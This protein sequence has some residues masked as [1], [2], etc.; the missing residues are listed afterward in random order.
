M[1]V[2][3]ANQDERLMSG[4]ALQARIEEHYLIFLDNAD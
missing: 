3:N 4:H 1:T 2:I